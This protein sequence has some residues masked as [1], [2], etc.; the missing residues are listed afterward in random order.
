[1]RKRVIEANNIVLN[2]RIP[3]GLFK[4]ERL[5]AVNNIS[6]EVYKGEMLSIIGFN[7]SGKTTM[8]SLISGILKPD[9]GSIKVHGRIVPFLGLGIG[10][11]PELSGRENVFL[12][13]TIMGL[14][15]KEII[16]V[17]DDIVEFSELKKF[18]HLKIKEYSSGMYVRL[19][20]SVAIHTHPDIL[21][22]DEV[23]AVGDYAF[24]QK[25]L[26]KIVQM[27]SDS[28][29][30]LFVSHNM[31][32]ITRFSDR[33]ILL[34]EGKLILEGEPETVVNKFMNMRK[35]IPI[36]EINRRGSREIIY[37][38]YGFENDR[39]EF[40]ENETALLILKYANNS[41]IEEAIPGFALYSETGQLITGPNLLDYEKRFLNPGRNGEIRIKIPMGFLN[42]GKYYISLGMYDKTNRFPYDHIEYAVNFTRTGEIRDYSGPIKPNIKWETK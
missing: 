7:G 17:Y 13:G 12:Y 30:I 33:V 41:K 24:Q 2:Y 16:K 14:K 35:E 23:L 37:T 19:G 6:F 3:C 39:D 27:K 42:P 31:G 8:L 40:A 11:N 38:N 18:M 21:I 29:T 9:K 34:N 36:P 5:T 26:N 4:T 1:M 20:F 15:R 10:F 28:K 25:C 22:I 32:L